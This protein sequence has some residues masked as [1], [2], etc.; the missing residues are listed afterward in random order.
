MRRK[1]CDR[2]F[3]KYLKYTIKPSKGNIKLFGCFSYNGVS[4]L[5]IIKGN[6]DVIMYTMNLNKNLK[7]LAKGLVL[8]EK[9]SF[10]EIMILNTLLRSQMI[11]LKKMISIF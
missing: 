10:S 4:I 1:M 9:L 7:K 3:Y 2:Y 5:E 8:N 6:I 11:G